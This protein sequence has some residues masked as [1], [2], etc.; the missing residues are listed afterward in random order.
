ML[1]SICTG[2]VGL[3]AL[4]VLVVET[5]LTT[6]QNIRAKFT[7]EQTIKA[8]RWN[9]GRASLTSALNGVG[10]QRHAPAALPLGKSPGTHCTGRLGTPHGLSGRVWKI[11][12]SPEFDP[13]TVHTVASRYTD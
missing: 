5:F 2:Q 1:P 8:R 13:Q 3:E 4:S 12:P 9:R 7:L 11:S 6:Y 10:G